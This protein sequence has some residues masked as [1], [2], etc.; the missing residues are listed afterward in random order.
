MRGNA[1]EKEDLVEAEAQEILECGAL[2]AAGGGLAGDEAVECG[3]PADDAADK[4]VAEAAISGGK[5]RGGEGGFEQMLGEFSAGQAL[6]Q[7]ARRNLSWILVVQ[8]V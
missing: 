7:D 5:A 2:L 1:V 4:L 8:G 6:G 3:L